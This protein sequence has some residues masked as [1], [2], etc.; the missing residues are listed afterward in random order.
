MAD[1]IKKWEYRVFNLG[2]LL[3]EVKPEEMEALLNQWG[4]E[5]WEL[6]VA[7]HHEG[8]NRV[9]LV[10]KRPASGSSPRRPSSWP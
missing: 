2:G 3:N 6:V 9:R 1:E 10:A 7:H 5:G 8:S 4:Q